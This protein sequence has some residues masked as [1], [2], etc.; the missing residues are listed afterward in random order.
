MNHPTQDMSQIARNVLIKQAFC[1]MM[2]LT[3][4]T[5]S[6]QPSGPAQTAAQP[7]AA[8]FLSQACCFEMIALHTQLQSPSSCSHLTP[9][10]C[11]SQNILSKLACMLAVVLAVLPQNNHRTK[12]QTPPKTNHS[13]QL[14]SRV[15]DGPLF[16]MCVC[17]YRPCVSPITR[18]A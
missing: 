5:G 10:I 15:D 16:H 7:S 9:R 1:Y 6:W 2:L 18:P 8:I 11:A 12:P 4:R 13:T 14:P 3:S 17:T